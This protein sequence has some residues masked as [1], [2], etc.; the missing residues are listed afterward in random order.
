MRQVETLRGNRVEEQ[1]EEVVSSSGGSA[2][3][4]IDPCLITFRHIDE[5]QQKNQHLLLVLRQVSEKQE[6][7][8]KNAVDARTA[9]IQQAL[10]NAQSEIRNLRDS[11]R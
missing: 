8:E 1:S 3:D 2:V 5:L 10:D 7:V 4:V 11:H 6:E 9:R